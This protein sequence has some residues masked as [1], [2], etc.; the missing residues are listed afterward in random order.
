M[1][2]YGY[3]YMP[4]YQLPLMKKYDSTTKE[5]SSHNS[6][7]T[8]LNAICHLWVR[9]RAS[10][11]FHVL[12]KC[13]C[14]CAHHSLTRLQWHIHRLYILLHKYMYTYNNK[15]TDNTILGKPTYLY[16]YVYIQI[17][18]RQY[19]YQWYLYISTITIHMCHPAKTLTYLYM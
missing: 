6:Y 14:V 11:K 4:S 3:L 19:L 17:L 12:S 7:E 9:K 13:V 5:I 15:H 1:D 16:K 18:I 10:I 8:I 2:T